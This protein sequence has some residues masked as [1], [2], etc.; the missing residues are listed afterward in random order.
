MLISVPTG[1]VFGTRPWTPADITTA[2]W[3][4]AADAGTITQDALGD[5][6]QWDDK[7]GNG[8]HAVQP[9]GNRQP[10]Y[11]A[12]QINGR[13]TLTFISSDQD[14]FETSTS[15]L[16]VTQAF[17]LFFVFRP[18][19]LGERRALLQQTDGTG[20][21]RSL[22]YHDET[23]V[24]ASLLGGGTQVLGVT[25]L[26]NGT[27]YLGEMTYN[28]S[29]TITFYLNGNFEASH[30]KTAEAADGFFR[31][32]TNKNANG[33][34]WEGQIAE[35]ACYQSVSDSDRQKTEGYLAWKWGLT[36]SLPVGHPYKDS[37]PE[38]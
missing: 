14:C 25:P 10:D 3:F 21:G 6:S 2:A 5:V 13:D 15:F 34:F 12:F 37:P 19:G 28:G 33:V 18:T 24:L 20:K 30:S 9:A 11:G 32:G 27:T 16:D 1:K 8:N 31:I 26:V 4:D 29:D 22:F 7:S 36:S 35:F 17:S 23:G 38:A